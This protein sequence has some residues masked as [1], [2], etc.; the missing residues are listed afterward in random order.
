MLFEMRNHHVWQ[1]LSISRWYCAG[2][3]ADRADTRRPIAGR[4]RPALYEPCANRAVPHSYL[5]NILS[6]NAEY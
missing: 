2:P 1:P 3:A 6:E 5:G 4:A